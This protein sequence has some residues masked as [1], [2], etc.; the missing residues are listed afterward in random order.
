MSYVP[1]HHL[2]FFSFEEVSFDGLK[3]VLTQKFEII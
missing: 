3:S 1:Y 2:A